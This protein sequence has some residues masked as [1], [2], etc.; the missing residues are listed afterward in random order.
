MIL[1]KFNNQRVNKYTSYYTY[2]LFK[3]FLTMKILLSVKLSKLKSN[4]Y[5][6][7]LGLKKGIKLIENQ[8]KIYY[9][10]HELIPFRLLRFFFYMSSLK[11]NFI[12]K[13]IPVK[14]MVYNG[15]EDRLI[16]IHRVY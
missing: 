4:Y 7:L 9:N 11:K 16:D 6:A 5:L 8:T 1:L 10:R 13:I 14:L 3:R 15:K 12:H 2:K